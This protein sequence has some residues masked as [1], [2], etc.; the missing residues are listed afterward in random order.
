MKL[1]PD[2]NELDLFQCWPYASDY[3]N[4]TLDPD[5][6]ENHAVLSLCRS[7]A[8]KKLVAFLGAGVSMAYGRISWQNLVLLLVEKAKSRW[9]AHRNS[10]PTKE[11]AAYRT[12][13]RLHKVLVDIDPSNRQDIPADRYPMIFEICEK[14]ELALDR[15]VPRSPSDAD[16]FRHEATRLTLDAEGHARE[17]IES[18]CR[19]HASWAELESGAKSDRSGRASFWRRLLPKTTFDQNDTPPS[20]TGIQS[21][22]H[23]AFRTST[24]RALAQQLDATPSTTYIRPLLKRILA[25]TQT[26]E[27]DTTA[28]RFLQPTHRFA[29]GSLLQAFP[30]DRR[31]AALA[32]ANS[33]DAETPISRDEMIPMD[34]DPLAILHGNVGVRRFITTN[35]DKEIEAFLESPTF[36]EIDPSGNPDR[37]HAE[38]DLEA[39]LLEWRSHVFSHDSPGHLVSFAVDNRN[40]SASVMHLHGRADDHK[41]MVVTETDYQQRYLKDDTRREIVDNA[42]R[43]AFSANPIVFVG[44]NMG[45]DD[46]MRPLRQFV[47]SPLRARDR[48]LIALIPATRPLQKRLEEKVALLGR[49]G[50]YAIHF[51]AVEASHTDGGTVMWLPWFW[52][53]KCIVEAELSRLNVLTSPT[54]VGFSK[55]DDERL[56]AEFKASLKVLTQRL[57][58]CPLTPAKQYSIEAPGNLEGI[59][60]NLKRRFSIDFEVSL[61]NSAIEFVKTHAGPRANRANGTPRRSREV[62]ARELHQATNVYKSAVRGAGDAVLSAFTCARLLK[63]QRDYD[64]WRNE[65]L[66]PPEMLEVRHGME[67]PPEIDARLAGMKLN[68]TMPNGSELERAPQDE[69]MAIRPTVETI[70]PLRVAYRHALQLDDTPT[71]GDGGKQPR[72]SRFYA[73]APSETLEELLWALEDNANGNDNRVRIKDIMGRRVFLFL[74]RDGVGRGHLLASLQSTASDSALLRFLTAIS[75]ERNENKMSRGP[76]TIWVSAIFCNLSYSQEAMSIFDRIVQV[77]IE[78]Y[79]EIANKIGRVK[80]A[81]FDADLRRLS[82]DR[83]GMLRFVLEHLD[84]LDNHPEMPL[85]YR[86]LVVINGINVLFD[87]DGQPKNGQVKRLF[88]VLLSKTRAKAPIDLVLLCRD[89]AV[90]IYFRRSSQGATPVWPLERHERARESANTGRISLSESAINFVNRNNDTYVD[91]DG[92][93]VS[94]KT[95]DVVSCHLLKAASPV[96]IALSFFSRIPSLLAWDR[97]RA[98]A[99]QYHEVFPDRA[100][101]PERVPNIFDHRA[102][103]G[104]AQEMVRAHSDLRRHRDLNV[105]KVFLQATVLVTILLKQN[106]TLEDADLKAM[107]DALVRDMND[108]FNKAAAR[109]PSRKPPFQDPRRTTDLEIAQLFCGT[110]LVSRVLNDD[111]AAKDR[112]ARLISDVASEVYEFIGRLYR[113]VSSHRFMFTILLSNCQDLTA[114]K[115]RRDEEDTISAEELTTA[116]EE[117]RNFLERTVAEVSASEGPHEYNNAIKRVLELQFQR[118]ARQQQLP[119]ALGASAC[120]HGSTDPRTATSEQFALQMEIIWALALVGQ[121]VPVSVLAAFPRV[122]ERARLMLSGSKRRDE[123]RSVEVAKDGET[124]KKR[125]GLIEDAIGEIIKLAVNRCQVF[126]IRSV[127][128]PPPKDGSS[129]NDYDTGFGSELRPRHGIHRLFQ[130]FVLNRLG[131]K[132]L[133]VGE[134]DRHTLSLFASQPNDMPSLEG[135]TLNMVRNTIAELALYPDSRRAVSLPPYGEFSAQRVKDRVR[136]ALGV[137][138]STYS[139]GVL[140]HADLDGSSNEEAEADPGYFEDYRRL[141]RWL[142]RLARVVPSKAWLHKDISVEPQRFNCFYAEEIVW[143]FNECGVLSLAQGRLSDA[144]GLFRAAR[145]SSWRIEPEAGGA[146]QTRIALNKAVVDIE[147]GE[148]SRAR[149]ALERIRAVPDQVE[150]VGIGHIASGYLGV[151]EYLA[152]N[153]DLARSLLSAAIEATLARHRLR[154]ASIFCRYFADLMRESGDQGAAMTIEKAIRMADEGGHEDVLRQAML[155][156]VALLIATKDVQKSREI[157]PILD[158]IESYARKI[159]IPRLLSEVNVQRA[160]LMLDLGESRLAANLSTDALQVATMQD[161]RPLQLRALLLLGEAYIS[162]GHRLAAQPIIRC[163]QALARKCEYHGLREG[164]RWLEAKAK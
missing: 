48:Q 52:E 83:V 150:L 71:L 9:E 68:P 127:G 3:A 95:S 147:R 103:I 145:V 79:V 126:A 91:V 16:S 138:R 24:A 156:R 161:M 109:A 72:F 11:T 73:N 15:L 159:G 42:I 101:S 111:S 130:S 114:E 63:V 21:D 90:P 57:L 105:A 140:A 67:V 160:R 5:A 86:I 34:R 12:A 27:A 61:I 115:E 93:A 1:A 97:L 82:S 66:Q 121:P 58:V 49:Y 40:N 13:E 151:I 69:N 135:R 29:I 89:D 14:L 37:Q 38:R 144:L 163:A 139:M 88:N 78:S 7:L 94:A 47:S 30:P 143:L 158:S 106:R 146:L 152:G 112:L 110:Q 96:M 134:V 28:S 39:S 65:W 55:L 41:S 31:L 113:G 6:I 18:A 162:G 157:Q 36:N 141:G 87:T 149:R 85:Q 62:Y 4:R 76:T 132:N 124:A 54:A 60:V 104:Y 81:G 26:S 2:Y 22:F 59:E 56:S 64:K 92:R 8:I 19:G 125:E 74:G 17:I 137:M 98:K 32:D 119:I 100:G 107:T 51:G 142:L 77:L 53:V 70:G 154:V 120:P 136:A 99:E 43:L 129:R 33:G 45:E 10:I 164:T 23:H 35:Y 108:A 84:E 148:L 102:G 133:E 131:A 44:S 46:I 25:N 123:W 117:I 80:P 50:V 122:N 118:H 20:S 153:F 128:L 116:A 155:S 75:R